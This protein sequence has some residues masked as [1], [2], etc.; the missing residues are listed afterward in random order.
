[1]EGVELEGSV[2]DRTAYRY[3][4]EQT[5]T[6]ADIRFYTEGNVF[7]SPCGKLF[8]LKLRAKAGTEAGNYPLR[9]LPILDADGNAE[10]LD[11]QGHEMSFALNRQTET[12]NMGAAGAGVYQSV[13]SAEWWQKGETD[14]SGD[15]L[16]DLTLLS[17]SITVV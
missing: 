11:K 5:D 2:L 6:G 16:A 1:M 8:D 12:Y 14:V 3:T 15:Q 17:G 9:L 7:S 4:V 13:D 10:L